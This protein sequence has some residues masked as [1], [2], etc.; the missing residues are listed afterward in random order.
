[1]TVGIVGSR[2]RNEDADFALVAR[3]LKQF[4]EVADRHDQKVI[5]VSGGCPVGADKFA[6][7]L[8]E[9]LDLD[10]IIHQADWKVGRHAGFLRNTDIANDADILIACVAEDRKGGTEDTIKKFCKKLGLT[11]EECVIAGWLILV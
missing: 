3:A 2:R 1:M 6:E 10:I 7:T 4:M 11:E 5:L 8:A 9:R